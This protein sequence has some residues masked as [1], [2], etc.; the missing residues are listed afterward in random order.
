MGAINNVFNRTGWSILAL[1][2]ATAKYRSQRNEEKQNKA[3]LSY[4]TAATTKKQ[5]N[6]LTKNQSETTKSYFGPG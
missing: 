4:T 5:N 2:N 1:A 3:K 6:E